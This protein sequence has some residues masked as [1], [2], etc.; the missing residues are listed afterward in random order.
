MARRRRASRLENRTSRLRLPIRG[1]PHDFTPLSPRVALGYRRNAKDTKWIVRLKDGH[2]GR[3]EKVLPDVVPD[4]F[5]DADGERVLDWWQACEAAIRF[6]HGSS[7][8]SEP[9][10]VGDALE[11]YQRDLI[12]RGQSPANAGVLRYHLSEPWLDK[13]V[14]QLG[15]R[16]F[17]AWRND[18]L[19]GGMVPASLA[20][21]ARSFKAALNLAARQD[22]R[23]TNVAAWKNGLGGI[24]EG[25]VSRNVQRLDDH[26]THAVI[27]AAYAIDRAF[28][29]YVEVGAVSGA[30]NS[31]FVR[32]LV[33]DLQ[34]AN[35]TPRLMM[36]SSRKGKGRKPGNYPVPITKSLA[37]KL[38]A[39]AG[40]RPPDAPLLLRSNGTPWGPN[41]YRQLYAE[42]ARRA[43]IT[44]TMT[45]LRHSSI[46]RQLLA[47]V[48]VRIVAVSHDTSTTMVERTYSAFIADHAD[49]LVRAA[50]LPESPPASDD[51]VRP[52]RR[53]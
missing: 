34:A 30:R 5:E 23:I 45:A 50:L 8:G 46:T 38:T 27:A 49:Q 43:G 17:F 9:T 11:L 35:G 44:G 39:A 2:G 47:A 31:Q 21:I 52:L 42:A 10:T 7:G 33:A 25:F 16:D 4:D 41:D 32:L 20:R 15:E 48:P 12:A 22:S 36:P 51:N 40:N 24:P 6:V 37:E 28:G 26:Q 53:R 14:A 1:K 29:L 13:V 19:E 18:K 3:S